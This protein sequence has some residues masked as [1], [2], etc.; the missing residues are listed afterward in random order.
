MFDMLTNVIVTMLLYI[1]MYLYVYNCGI[2]QA[3][4]IIK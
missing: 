1:Y 2:I 3:R 4:L